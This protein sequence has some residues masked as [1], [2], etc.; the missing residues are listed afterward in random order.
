MPDPNATMYFRFQ[1]DTLE[2]AFRAR[3]EASRK[4]LEI[5]ALQERQAENTARRLLSAGVSLIPSEVLADNQFMVSRA[6]F[7][8]AR[9]LLKHEKTPLHPNPLHEFGDYI[10]DYI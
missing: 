1:E 2:S 9:R 7:E 6:V 10:G 5:T 3:L 4:V 8:A